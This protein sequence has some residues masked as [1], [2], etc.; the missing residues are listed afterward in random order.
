[1]TTQYQ[2]QKDRGFFETLTRDVRD[3]RHYSTIRRDY[4]ELREFYIGEEELRKLQ[5]RNALMRA[6][7]TAWWLLK[8]LFYNLTPTR[9]LIIVAGLLLAVNGITLRIGDRAVS[10]NGFSGFVLVLFVLILEL[11]DKL[12]AHHELESGRAIQQALMPE[13]CPAITGWSVWMSSRPAREVGGDLVDCLE[14][15]RGRV[16]ILLADVAGKGLRAALLATRLQATVRALAADHTSLSDL[17]ARI[18]AIFHRDSIKS[19]FASLLY[20]EV[21]PDSGTIR[22]V[23]AGHLPPLIV[24]SQGVREL[25]KGQRAL[26]LAGGSAYVEHGLELQPGEIFLAF[27]DGLTE[28]LN[29][30]GELYGTERLT[31]RLFFLR[32]LNAREIGETIRRDVEAFVGDM[33]VRDDLSMVVL[34]KEG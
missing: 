12:L 13:S 14:V 28:A 15:E 29:N 27:T 30:R 5:Q 19:I 6:L 26:G 3:G 1:M 7:A 21:R 16:A 9:R 11:K 25:D 10:D 18:N 8:G 32:H 31:K 2:K 4:R 17:C 23:N 34:K 24:S 33:P 22:Y 20:L